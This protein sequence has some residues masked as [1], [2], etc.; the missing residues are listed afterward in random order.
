LYKDIFLS[1]QVQY[2]FTIIRLFT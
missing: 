1:L 2:L